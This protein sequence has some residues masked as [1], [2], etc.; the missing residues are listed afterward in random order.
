MSKSERKVLIDF[1]CEF[2]PLYDPRDMRKW[3]DDEL[4]TIVKE[5]AKDI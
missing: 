5:I 2:G 4:K 1:V 3:T